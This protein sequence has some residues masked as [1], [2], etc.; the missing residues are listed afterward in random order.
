[1]KNEPSAKKAAAAIIR[2]AMDSGAEEA[3]TVACVNYAGEP[4]G[5]RGILGRI[6]KRY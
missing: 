4:D 2:K 1:M 3:L 5:K 6:F